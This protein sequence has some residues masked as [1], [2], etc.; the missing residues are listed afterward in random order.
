MDLVRLLTSSR[1]LTTELI[2][3]HVCKSIQIDGGGSE[4][5]SQRE[6]GAESTSQVCVSVC[7]CKNI[8]TSFLEFISSQLSF[9]EAVD[10]LYK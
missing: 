9:G 8:M 3:I 10:A 2:R 5:F 7:V 1:S 6:T 4:V